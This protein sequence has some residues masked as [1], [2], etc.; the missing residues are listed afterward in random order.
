MQT[1]ELARAGDPQ[2]SAAESSRL[3]TKE[4]SVQARAALLPQLNGSADYTRTKND[5]RGSQVFGRRSPLRR[6]TTTTDTNT[7]SYGVDLRQMVYD[8]GNFTRLRSANALSEA[9]DFQLE[10]AG[11]SLITR[12]SAAYFNVLVQLETLAAA[13]AAETALKKQ[14]DF[15]SKRL[16]VGLAP[17]TDVHEAR[18]QYDSARANTITVRNRGRRRLPGAGRNHRPAD[19]ATSRACR[20]TSSRSCPTPPAPTQWV[21][22]AHR[23]QSGADGQGTARCKSAEEDVGTARAG[24]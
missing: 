14:F 17:I 18:A 10:S 23:Q 13:E 1:Y 20:K 19:R 12:T 8:R 9:S 4:G 11:D 2:F 22:M 16:E 7:R 24:H 21:Q 15:A 3:A 5:I 6:T